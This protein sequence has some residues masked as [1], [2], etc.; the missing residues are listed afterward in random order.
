VAPLLFATGIF[1]YFT[2]L[3]API[4]FGGAPFLVGSLLL[5]TALVIARRV[6]AGLPEK[7]PE[8]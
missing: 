5:F 3:K 4:Q 1:G 2:S 7:S 6:F 8:A